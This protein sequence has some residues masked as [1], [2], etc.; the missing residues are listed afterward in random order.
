VLVPSDFDPDQLHDEI[1][2]LRGLVDRLSEVIGTSTG[3]PIQITDPLVATDPVNGGP[4]TWHTLGT[5]ALYTVTVGRFRKTIDNEVEIDIEVTEQVTAAANTNF[6]VTL[7]AAYQPLVGRHIPLVGT[8]GVTAADPWPRL[9]V[10]AGVV[11]VV[12]AGGNTN[13][14]GVNVRLPLD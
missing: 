1:A 14:W 12:N 2:Q 3:D 11:Q 10:S 5:L 6:S 7:P 9:F 13:V 8:R 4:E